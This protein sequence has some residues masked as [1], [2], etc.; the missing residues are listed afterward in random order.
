MTFD[1]FDVDPERKAR[2]DAMM[3]MFRASRGVETGGLARL[4][5]AS[6]EAERLSRAL[7]EWDAA[8]WSGD[9]DEKLFAAIQVERATAAAKA[10]RE[11]SGQ[12]GDDGAA[13][14][15]GSF[16]SGVRRDPWQRRRLPGS[17]Q[18]S[19]NQMFLEALSKA[20]VER[21]EAGDDDAVIAMNT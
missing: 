13:P 18:P 8:K 17:A 5:G 19:A 11:A 15:G 6:P 7:N 10:A 9:D 2:A 20:R 3:A 12:P 14:A 16:D 1:L 4:S 21:E